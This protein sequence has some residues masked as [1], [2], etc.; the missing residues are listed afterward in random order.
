MTTGVIF[1]RLWHLP[2][3]LTSA[4]NKVPIPSQSGSVVMLWSLSLTHT[5]LTTFASTVSLQTAGDTSTIVGN[6]QHMRW[7]T[8]SEVSCIDHW[9]NQSHLDHIT[10][11]DRHLI[12]PVWRL[13]LDIAN[14]LSMFYRLI[15]TA[16]IASWDDTR[17]C[18]QYLR[19]IL[20]RRYY[21]RDHWSHLDHDVAVPD[22]H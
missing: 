1:Q 7:I 5:L 8:Q 11:P 15:P 19:W 18:H 20:N 10:V 12:W 9:S 21:M 14:A 4:L 16:S 3:P 13:S 22:R 17:Q 2:T 6:R